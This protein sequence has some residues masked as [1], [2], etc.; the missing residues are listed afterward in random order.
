MLKK[1]KSTFLIA[2]ICSCCLLCGASNA[3]SQVNV[4][5]YG[6][7]GDGE[8]ND[9]ESINRAIEACSEAGG[10]TVVLPTGVYM[11]GTIYL[12]SN[13]NLNIPAGTIL[14]GVKDYEAYLY[15]SSWTYGGQLKFAPNEVRAFIYA[16]DCENVAITGGG[17]ID[18][19]HVFNKKLFDEHVKVKERDLLTGWRGSELDR[20]PHTIVINNSK[21]ILIRDIKVINSPNY[22]IRFRKCQYINIT[23]FTAIGGWDGI[24]ITGSKYATISNC[25]IQSGDDGFAL[26]YNDYFVITNCLVNSACNAFRLQK[27]IRNLLVDNCILYGP[28]EN[29][30]ISSHRNNVITGFTIEPS[31]RPDPKN[32]DLNDYTDD[33]RISNITMKGIRCPFYIGIFN[34]NTGL[35]NVHVNDVSVVSA[36]PVASFIHGDTDVAVEN[37]SFTNVR[38]HTVGGGERR[39][40]D[41]PVGHKF[42]IRPAYGF[43]CSRVKNIEFHDV[44]MEF[45]NQDIRPGLI[46]E[47]V[48]FVELDNVKIERGHDNPYPIRMDN[49]KAVYAHNMMDVATVEPLY[50]GLD[51]ISNLPTKHPIAGE[52]F[53]VDVRVK[54]NSEGLAKAQLSLAGKEY[55]SWVWLQPQKEKVVSFSELEIDRSGK[56]VATAGNINKDCI[57]DERPDG[58]MFVYSGFDISSSVAPTNIKAGVMV[59]NIGKK[60]G[61]ENVRLFVDKKV[62]DQKDITLEAAEQQFVHFDYRVKKKNETVQVAIADELSKEVSI[63]GNVN[64]PYRILGGREEFAYQFGSKN[65]FYIK[66]KDIAY[67]MHD[68]F[69]SIYLDNEV[70]EKSVI[71]VKAKNPHKKGGWNGRTGLVLKNDITDG[72]S[73]GYIVLSVSG[74]NGWSMDWDTDGEG[75]LDEHTP[76]DGF[77]EWPSWLKIERNGIDFTGYYSIDNKNWTKVATVSVPSAKKTMDAGIFVF[78]TASEFENFE[79]V[80]SQ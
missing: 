79:V 10:G 4:R 71:K 64:R 37:I 14:R 7:K 73:D 26:H 47:H 1:I 68:E 23:G 34:G 61:K 70:Q 48:D 54:A 46:C 51:V 31:G 41:L 78:D 74:S 30:H 57:V 2:I 49:V 28:A 55:T 44:V 11:A 25:N 45:E 60:K 20:G 40:L 56:F 76:Y 62:A 42:D 16:K 52:K 69:E 12:K 13:V 59:K 65:H 67:N 33:I 50:L 29:E 53:S 15:L 21:D 3:L 75:I 9:T 22:S 38:I 5:D 6:A 63:P 66:W 24:N 58:A 8:T 43:F 80:N 36:S 39:H 72:F 27:G 18:G 19:N 77:S 32:P 17:T 35:K